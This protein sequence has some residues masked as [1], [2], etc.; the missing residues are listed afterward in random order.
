MI[1]VKNAKAKLEKLFNV[2]AKIVDNAAKVNIKEINPENF[3]N[4]MLI[5]R[6]NDVT[7]RRSG[8]GLTVIVKPN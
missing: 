7:I 4:L 2:P 3:Q 1:E 5:G 6:W 8:A